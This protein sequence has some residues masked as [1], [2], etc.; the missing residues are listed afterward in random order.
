MN[1]TDQPYSAFG[2]NFDNVPT[3]MM[4][5]VFAAAGADLTARYMR[6]NRSASTQEEQDAWWAKVLQLRNLK[7]SVPAH[8]RA[9]LIEHIHQWRAELTE[10]DTDGRG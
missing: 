5:E 9:A 10:L 1:T 3:A 7:N 2:E 6:F 4:Y 8:D